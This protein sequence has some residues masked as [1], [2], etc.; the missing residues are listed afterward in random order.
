MSNQAVAS[1]LELPPVPST[2]PASETPDTPT[3]TPVVIPAE[4]K[5]AGGEAV[6]GQAVAM[7]LTLDPPTNLPVTVRWTTA[8]ALEGRLATA[9]VDYAARSGELVIPPGTG[10][11]E[12]LVATLADQ[13]DELDEVFRLVLLEVEGAELAA[14]ATGATDTAEAEARIL[15]DDLAL[16]TI[17][18]IL[19][20]EGD[21]GTTEGF[22]TVRLSMPSDREVHL[23]WATATDAAAA[24]AATADVD[25]RSLSGELSLP[26]GETAAT[27]RVEIFGDTL[28]EE[29]DESFRVELSEIVPAGLGDGVG[30]ATI[31]GGELC[32]GPN[33]LVNAGA[34]ERG[35]GDALPGWRRTTGHVERLRLDA[36]EPVDGRAVFFGGIDP[37]PTAE[38]VQDVD[39]GAY[40]DR[41]DGGTQ[42]FELRA[43]VRTF[44]ETPP[45]VVRLVVEYLDA[46]GSV[47]DRFDS[48]ELTS[49]FGWSEVVDARPAPPSTRS[50]RLRLEAI[51]FNG[52]EIDAFVDALVFR[53]LGTP[54]V[55]LG[56]GAASE[57]V[58]ALRVPVR[59]ACPYEHP[60]TLRHAT[61]DGDARAGEDYLAVVDELPLAAGEVASEIVVELIDD[62]LA[63]PPESFAVDVVEVVSSGAPTVLEPALGTILDNDFC[64]R[65]HGYWK[66]HREVWPVD[67]VEMG[68]VEFD[69]AA[70]MEWLEYKGGAAPGHLTL[71]FVATLLNLAMGSPASSP[72]GAPSIL[73]A[74]EQAHAYLEEFPPGTDPKGADKERGNAIKDLL[75]AY[76]TSCPDEG[77][78]SGGGGNGNGNGKG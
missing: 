57:S 51:R 50:A 39:L 19:V 17:D 44:E 26:P 32:A 21:A 38:L 56:D 65:S 8:D 4:L 40:A 46:G 71:Q 20:D 63:E 35:S 69:D 33:L 48:G 74:I 31:V 43:W 76:N 55:R 10:G 78:G 25:Y 11:A 14:D 18:D 5:L 58:G 9:N 29:P 62:D 27:L 52:Q 64:P 72:E 28:H 7:T 47:L 67:W 2:D 77:G 53:S 54:V 59:L 60:I 66:T 70:M 75:D 41:I 15:D 6:E 16:V 61:V 36:L 73:P 24:D 42:R 45:D 68:G 34:E 49:P 22:F 23:R 3:L 12:I 13:V 30:L 37:A 1:S